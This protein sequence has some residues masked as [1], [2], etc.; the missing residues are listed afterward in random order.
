MTIKP[1][2]NL[3]LPEDLIIKN[4]NKLNY[5]KR[6]MDY[7]PETNNFRYNNQ[8]IFQFNSFLDMQ[9]FWTIMVGCNFVQYSKN[10]LPNFDPEAL[11]EERRSVYGKDSYFKRRFIPGVNAEIGWTL[12]YKGARPPVVFPT[13]EGYID[14]FFSDF[15][16][17]TVNNLFNPFKFGYYKLEPGEII[18]PEEM[19]KYLIKL[20]ISY[21][22]DFR[23][24]T[25]FNLPSLEFWKYMVH[26]TVYQ[27]DNLSGFYEYH[28]EMMSID[29][30]MFFLY[31]EDLIDCL[32]LT[33]ESFK[34]KGLSAFD[35]TI[36]LAD[37]SYKSRSN[38]ETIQLFYRLLDYYLPSLLEKLSYQASLL[39]SINKI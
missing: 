26:R 11:W 37:E 22:N 33:G 9:Y 5:Y 15:T 21:L 34:S 27:G 8:V 20:F 12:A 18:T 10:R 13:D 19:Q 4:P 1:I 3:N 14:L 2:V 7:N 24:K 36:F 32:R 23:K 35:E 25:V 30:I 16:E 39:S 28:M 29:L 38:P 6:L 17:T 31:K